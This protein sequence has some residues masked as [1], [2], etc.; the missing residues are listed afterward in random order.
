MLEYA[1]E[2][3]DNIGCPTARVG[4][5]SESLYMVARI[6]VV[7]F[8]DSDVGTRTD[9]Q[10]LVRELIRPLRE[11]ASPG[12]ARVC[13]GVT[14]ASF[15]RQDAEF[16]GFA[17]PLWGLAPLAAGGGPF[18]GWEE[19]RKGLTNG[20]DPDHP[21][22]WGSIPDYS[23]KAV[24]LAPL[25]LGLA[26]A[27]ESLWGPLSAET[28]SAVTT[29]MRGVEKID[30]PDNNWLWFRVLATL[31]LRS[32]GADHDW[33]RVERDLDRLE[34]FA[35]DDGWYGDGPDGHC[36]YYSAWELQTDALVYSALVEDDER[37]SRF[38]ER[39]TEF[40]KEFQYWFDD[41]GAGL[42]FG[43]SLTYRFAQGAFWG[44]LAFAD[45]E[46]LPWRQVRGLWQRHLQWWLDQPILT[47][48]G[49]LSLGYRY[50]TLK[51]T[52]PYNSPS[53][54]Y[55]GMKTF[56]P[57]ALPNDHPF[58][59]VDPTPLPELERECVQPSPGMVL[60]R[61][62]GDV[63]ALVAGADVPYAHKYN[64]FA[65]STTFGFGV[66][67]DSH[68]LA[69]AGVDSTLALSED[70]DHFRARTGVT[71]TSVDGGVV[72]SQWEPWPDTTVETWLVPSTPWHVRIHRMELGRPLHNV[73]GGFALGRN[74]DENSDGIDEQVS[75]GSAFT[76]SSVGCSG[77]RDLS[78]SRTGVVVDQDPNTNLLFPRSSVPV[79][80]DTHEPG[81]EWLVTGVM[82][83]SDN[84]SQWREGPTLVSDDDDI[85]IKSSDGRLLFEH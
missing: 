39:A 50:P 10:R 56:L 80:R 73:D 45:V 31:G 15:P 60:C 79:L 19:Y 42:P 53:S 4:R 40:A 3:A 35:F 59:T 18:D 71:D 52:E 7:M 70:G 34:S 72:H 9:V 22:Y 24:E 65:Y 2:G 17:R 28:R 14:G 75:A 82:A 69:K 77:V 74:E 67:S 49:V 57:L 51:M 64:K 11:Y 76:R 8:F 43:R 66:A 46:A 85:R 61:D 78:A 48:G 29:W 54:P 23:Q 12:N 81:T 44:A 63:T 1:V 68:G 13:P 33:S 21:E 6:E 38:C 62:R 32:V 55:W 58:W 41:D 5:G 26:L 30:L 25:G 20:T 16:E 47:D 27:P 83:A 36:D 84:D 37:T